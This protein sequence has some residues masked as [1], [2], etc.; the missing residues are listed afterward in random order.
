MRAVIKKIGINGEGIGYID[1]TP[2]FIPGALIDEEVDFSI[3]EKKPKYVIGKMNRV[4]KQSKFRIQP[5]CFIQG[6]CGACPLMIT[7]YPKQLEYKYEILKQSLIKYAQV[8]PR[9]IQSV[10]GGEDAFAYANQF[11]L[12]CGMEEGVLLNGMYMPNSNIFIEVK[13][14]WIHEEA[15]ERLRGDVMH[16]LNRF[17]FTSYDFHVK[18]GI[19]SLIIRGFEGQ[20]QCTIVTGNDKINERVIEAL[21][22]LKGM[23]SLWQSV[24]TIKKT[25]D[26]FGP[27]MT[28]L[29]GER[30]LPFR[31]ENLKL[32]IS[33][34]SFYQ[35][36]TKQAAK[37]YKIIDSMVDANNELL[38][39]AYSGIGAISLFLKD[40]ATEIIGI[41][42]MKD[43]VTNANMNAKANGASHVSFICDDAANK[44]T[45]ISK[46]RS[47]DVLLLDPPRAGLDDD[48]L[49]C[50]LKSRIKNII[51]VSCNPATLGKDISILSERYKVVK[52]QPIDIF[53]HTAEVESVVKLVRK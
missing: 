2:V 19:R 47:I 37:L 1:R 35:Y 11:K 27:K 52:V 23:H 3:A 51:Y 6:A 21:M 46:T 49:E 40:K 42:S 48:M 26:I 32:E 12:P 13:K 41:E 33:P 25:P 10:M 50:I 39:D 34:R 14:C 4:I 18:M 43:A 20:Y 31:L 44:L 22:K 28:L 17:G 9:L 7:R 16:V 38:V 30:Y 45:Y 53:P 8:N 29:A 36:N 5:K 24:H 15:L